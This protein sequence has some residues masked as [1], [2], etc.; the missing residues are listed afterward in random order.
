MAQ[1]LPLF[2]GQG[3]GPVRLALVR[4]PTFAATGIAVGV[5]TKF[6]GRTRRPREPMN[7]KQDA[8][9]HQCQYVSDVVILSPRRPSDR[10]AQILPGSVASYFSGP[11]TLPQIFAD[12]LHAVSG[13]EDVHYIAGAPRELRP[14][15]RPCDDS[16][17]LDGRCRTSSRR[18]A[19]ARCRTRRPRWQ[20][21]SRTFA[22]AP[23]RDGASRAT[24]A[25]PM[26]LLLEY[27][28][29]RP[30]T[31]STPTRLAPS[32]A[33]PLSDPGGEWTASDSDPESWLP[34]GD[35]RG[36]I[37]RVALKDRQRECDFC[38]SAHLSFVDVFAPTAAASLSQHSRADC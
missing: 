9:N 2:F 34:A 31:C 16:G 10:A 12:T 38:G 1:P 11:R 36:L 13:S 28:W 20:S 37:E 17:L 33:L 26:R 35:Q 15:S 30:A 24:S 25:G 32:A 8:D 5:T 7:S 18:S 22:R 19:T 21:A 6:F 29:L 4:D 27:M 23:Q 14:R 3:S